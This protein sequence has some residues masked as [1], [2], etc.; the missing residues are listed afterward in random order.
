MIKNVKKN[1]T[2]CD[3][4]SEDISDKSTFENFDVDQ[5]QIYGR[6]MKMLGFL[7]CANA[8][9]VFEWFWKPVYR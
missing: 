9:A 1:P 5:N 3:L 8:S 2:R 7:L 4:A 6:Q